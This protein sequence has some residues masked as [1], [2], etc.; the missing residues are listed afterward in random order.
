[1]KLKEVLR[2]REKQQIGQNLWEFVFERPRNFAFAAGQY[3]E[4]TLAHPHADTRGNRRYFTISS[5]PTERHVRI[6][7]RVEE[8]GSSFKK[9][10]VAMQPGEEIVAGQV[11]GEFVLPKN[12]KEKLAFLAG[13]IGVTPMRS[14]LKHLADKNE[15]RDVVMLYSARTRG[16]VAYADIFDEAAQKTGAKIFYCIS[17][18]RPESDVRLAANI[19]LGFVDAEVIRREIPDFAERTFYISGPRAMVVAFE[20]ALREMG[21]HRR[22]IKIDFFPGFA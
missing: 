10:L 3:L 8:Q 7:V 2:L 22:K 11:A 17:D 6:G 5:A 1:P 19:R 4:W 16:A 21:V 12:P 15:K 14:M 9:K 13:G 18:E 20:R